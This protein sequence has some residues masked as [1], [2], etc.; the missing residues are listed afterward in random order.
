MP[1][2]LFLPEPAVASPACERTMQKSLEAVSRHRAQGT[3]YGP[4]SKV[5]Q[6]VLDDLSAAGYWGLLID[7]QY[8]GVGA[9][10]AS[11]AR[12]LTR[13]ATIEPN[14]A[15]LASVH[16][17]IGAVDP[18]RTFGTRSRKSGI[19]PGWPAASGFRRSP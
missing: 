9:P 8:G 18:L 15:G 3:L 14:L 16:G 7:P 12:F 19:F 2:E 6:A 1:A 11:F 13:M 10:F 4:D 5:S 17:C